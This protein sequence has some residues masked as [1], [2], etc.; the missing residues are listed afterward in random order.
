VLGG[1]FDHSRDV[2]RRR[3]GNPQ[4]G[5]R[6]SQL[7]DECVESRWSEDEQRASRAGLGDREAMR[8]L[9][10][11]EDDRAGA[12]CPSLLP[13]EPFE[14]AVDDEECLIGLGDVCGAAG[15]AGW[16]AVVDDRETAS[17]VLAGDLV[18]R[19][20]VQE[21]ERIALIPG[22]DESRLARLPELVIARVL[23]VGKPRRMVA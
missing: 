4:L 15:E 5:R 18:Q 12:G 9:T 17:G 20:R 21:P 1:Q 7:R 23:A 19:E 8:D 10:R 6:F 11:Q 14:L 2:W 3:I 16:N 13:A 22:K